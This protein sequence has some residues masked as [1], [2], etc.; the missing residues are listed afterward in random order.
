MCDCK[1]NR[2]TMI[3]GTIGGFFAYAMSN[4]MGPLFAQDSKGA[5]KRIVV[6]WMSGGP[7]HI[8]TFDPKPGE[9]T[10]GEAYDPHDGRSVDSVKKPSNRG[11]GTLR[12]PFPEET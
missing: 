2:R 1:L 6:L 3:G 12:I 11:E 10:G 5:A 4:G 7:S 9:D 8:D